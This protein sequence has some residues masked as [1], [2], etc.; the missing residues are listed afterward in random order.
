MDELRG[1]GIPFHEA[2]TLLAWAMDCD[3]GEV[4]LREPAPEQLARYRS[5]VGVRK[6]GFPLQYLTG[7]AFFRTVRVEVGPGVFI[8]RPETEVLVGWALRHLAPGDTVV[9][10]CAGSGAISLALAAEGPG[11]RQYAV[12]VDE[13][14]YEYAVRNLAGT[15]VD[16]RL[17]DM[18][19]AFL[20]LDGSVDLV[21]ANPPYIPAGAEV[22][23]EVRHEP[24]RALFA[25]PDG[26][27]AIAVVATVAARLLKPG[28]I[29]VFEHAEGNGGL[30]APEFCDVQ[31]LADLA[32]RP[33]FTTAR[34]VVAINP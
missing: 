31:T 27:D 25:G 22:P 30:E 14:A 5:A 26:R 33:R 12:E 17:G 1:A 6:T 18:A 15:G 24:E 13:V 34:S 8:P 23:P 4:L 28:G 32:G 20:E 7:E 11:C 3:A 21:I 2:V 16:V 9:E 10:L 29:L 19:G